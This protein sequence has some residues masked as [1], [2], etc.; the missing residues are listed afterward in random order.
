ME[1]DRRIRYHAMKHESA[2]KDLDVAMAKGAL[3]GVLVVVAAMLIAL[4]FYLT[5]GA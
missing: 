1:R 5:S 2:P 4:L 3:G